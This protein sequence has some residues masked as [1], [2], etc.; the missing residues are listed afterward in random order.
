MILKKIK[1]FFKKKVIPPQGYEPVYVKE[2]S[3][4]KGV[5]TLD[6]A[7]PSLAI[8]AESVVEF[9]NDTYAV[10]YV[11]TSFWHPEEGF[12]ELIVRKKEKKSP[13]ELHQELLMAVEQKHPGETRHE[14][15]LR[16]IRETENSIDNHCTANPAL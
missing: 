5:M 2:M 16:Y 15:A 11:T 12:M 4:K 9:F 10:N 3:F 13:S 7:H 14:T 1:H 6:L 8:F